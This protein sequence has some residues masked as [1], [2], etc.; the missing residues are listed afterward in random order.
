MEKFISFVLGTIIFLYLFG[1]VAKW[2]LRFWLQRKIKQMQDNPGAGFG[3]NFSGGGFNFGGFS[4]GFSSNAGGRGSQS[5]SHKKKG[6]VT[7]DRQNAEAKR[8]NTQVGEYVDFE[9]IK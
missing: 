7:I 8:V 6:D 5:Q 1:I 9:E 4:G 3:G 2:L